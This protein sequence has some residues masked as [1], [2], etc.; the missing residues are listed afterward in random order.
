[1]IEREV[2]M[3]E[4]ARSAWWILLVL[5]IV[6]VGFG[7]LLIFWPGKT[8]TVVTTVVGLFMV[9]AGIARFFVG[10]FDSDRE[11]RIL[12]V[13][14][15]IVGVVVGVAIM[16][17]PE[18]AIKLVV[19]LTALFWIISGMIDLFR[20]LSDASLPDRSVR[21]GFGAMS[22][23]FGVVILAWPDMTVGVFA[24]LMGIYVLFFGILEIVAA[25]QLKNA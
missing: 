1:M 11:Y 19:L 8:L 7:A 20:G 17:N 25:F 9:V 24:V 22:A 13:L 21:I 16:R 23:V 2:R 18:A 14:A 6:S 5:G 4:E 12:M 3:E 10:V 15:G